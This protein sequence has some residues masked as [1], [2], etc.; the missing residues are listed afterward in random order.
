MVNILFCGHDL[1]FLTPV[2]NFV[3][4][5]S[6]TSVVVQQTHGHKLS[7]ADIAESEKN[8]EKADVIFC[9][10]ALDN[11]VWFSRHKRDGQLL[12]VRMH[13]QEFQADIPYLSRIDFDKVDSFIV[14]CQ[15]AVDY[16]GSHYPAVKDKVK[17]IYN[18]IDIVGRFKN[19][20]HRNNS[21]NTRST[22][23]AGKHGCGRSCG[24]FCHINDDV[25][26]GKTTHDHCDI[27]GR[28]DRNRRNCKRRRGRKRNG[29]HVEGD[30]R[31][32]RS[33]IC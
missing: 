23:S 6:S 28:N 26:D 2:V 33:R 3:K 7:D 24:T 12:V 15:E 17:L 22:R 14:I 16:M 9:E 5:L 18:P 25:W 31:P 19:G 1:K 11:V 10:W 29:R 4:S 27:F 20:R 30:I 21:R 32:E 13:A 8:I